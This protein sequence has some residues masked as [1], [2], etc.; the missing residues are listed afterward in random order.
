LADLTPQRFP[1]VELSEW[2]LASRYLGLDE[3]AV[4]ISDVA[5]A[6]AF[7]ADFMTLVRGYG[8]PESIQS[9]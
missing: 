5:A 6:L 4:T 2:Y 7:V 1:I 3:V 8:P 9:G